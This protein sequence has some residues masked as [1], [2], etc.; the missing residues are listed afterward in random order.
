MADEGMIFIF[1]DESPR[2]F[3]MANVNFPLDILFFDRT[4]ALVKTHTMAAEPHVPESLLRRYPSV[5]PAQFAVEV[6]AGWV[7]DHKVAPPCNLQLT[8]KIKPLR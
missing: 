1:S 2:Q 8:E 7:A 5:I 4:G 6:R 3:W